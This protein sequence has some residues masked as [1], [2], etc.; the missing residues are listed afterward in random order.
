MMANYETVKTLLISSHES[1]MKILKLQGIQTAKIESTADTA[2]SSLSL[3]SSCRPDIVTSFNTEITEKI[4][5][6]KASLLSDLNS[7]V[8]E[9]NS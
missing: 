9:V 5:A 1:C 8:T 4:A 2:I 3:D 6:E 7:A